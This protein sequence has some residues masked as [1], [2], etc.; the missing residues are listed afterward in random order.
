MKIPHKSFNF[1]KYVTETCVKFQEYVRE[2]C[3]TN[4]PYKVII[5]NPSAMATFDETL[6]NE[7]KEKLLP[8]PVKSGSKYLSFTEV[9]G[10]S[11]SKETPDLPV[12]SKSKTKF[13]MGFS[14]HPRNCRNIVSQKK[15]FECGTPRMVFSKRS[16]SGT[17]S[18]ELQTCMNDM[19]LL[20]G[21]IYQGF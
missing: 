12:A 19:I 1:L 13:K 8:S 16:L 6:V 18:R 21:A 7:L 5:Q 15:C 20:V 4:N 2:N 17:E 11:A 14:P 9:Y 3:I 10:S